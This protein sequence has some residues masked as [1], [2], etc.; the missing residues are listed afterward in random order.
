MSRRF[1]DVDYKTK[2]IKPYGGMPKGMRF[3]KAEIQVAP[4]AL[5][6]LG[7]TSRDSLYLPTISKIV[8]MPE[9]VLFSLAQ[10]MKTST[11]GHLRDRFVDHRKPYF[12]ETKADFQ[13]LN[14]PGLIYDTSKVLSFSPTRKD[15]Y[16]FGKVSRLNADSMVRWPGHPMTLRRSRDS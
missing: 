7:S 4:P 8:S 3:K 15:N 5:E 16:S 11:N 10:N 1:Y 2:W 14:T 13:G 12:P 9:R 6:P